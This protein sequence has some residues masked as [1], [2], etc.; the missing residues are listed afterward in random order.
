MT[1]WAPRVT[2]AAIIEQQDKFLIVEENIDGRIVLNQPAGHLEENETLLEAVI[3]EVREETAWQFT[4]G[5]LVGIYRMHV[6]NSGLTYLRFCFS[7]QCADHRPQQPLDKE[8][9]RTLWLD[10]QALLDR[11]D[12]LRSPL[13]LHCIDDYLSGRRFPLAILKDLGHV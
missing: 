1:T 10:R 8:I 7:G 4:P 2:V 11:K 13:V 6:D 12:S 9:V 5:E 3:R